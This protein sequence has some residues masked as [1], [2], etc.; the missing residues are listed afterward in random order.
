MS[1]RKGERERKRKSERER[2]R[3]REK[4]RKHETL[5]E[6]VENKRVIPSLAPFFWCLSARVYVCV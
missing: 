4:E 1:E 6:N 2:E 5:C 3:E